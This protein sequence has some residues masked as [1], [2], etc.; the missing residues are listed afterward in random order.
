MSSGHNWTYL[1][2]HT[3]V[4][5]CLSRDPE[6]PL[7]E[8]AAEVGITERSVQRII[9]DLEEAGALRRDRV[10]RNN[11]YRIYRSASLRHPL[12]ARCKL[13]KLLD[14]VDKR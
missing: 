5:V 11:R 8:V 14:L 4:L 10:G 12:E 1:S 3:H 7:R 2:N 6:Q 13:G 9:N